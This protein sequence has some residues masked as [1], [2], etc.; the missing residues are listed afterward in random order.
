LQAGFCDGS[1]D[2]FGKIG[3]ALR[4]RRRAGSAEVP[5]GGKRDIHL[6][7]EAAKKVDVT[8]FPISAV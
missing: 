7:V 3:R 5:A 8:L 2:E 4:A 6:L 1:D